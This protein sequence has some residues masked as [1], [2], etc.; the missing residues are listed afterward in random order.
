MTIELNRELKIC[1]ESLAEEKKTTSQEL[2][3]E[4]LVL[5]FKVVDGNV[6]KESNLKIIKDITEVIRWK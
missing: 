3:L 5:A 6:W 4:L 1:I 2:I